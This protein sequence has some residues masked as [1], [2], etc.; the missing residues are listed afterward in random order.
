MNLFLVRHA[1]AVALELSGVN[2]DADRPLTQQGHA[3]S[4]AVATALLR[5]GV[6]LELVLTSPYLRCRQTTQGL[7]DAWAESRPKVEECEELAPE[8]KSGKL[9]RV[10][11]KQKVENLGVVGHMP[12]L[13]RYA[14]WLIGSKKARLDFA[15]ASVG[16]IDFPE[17]PDKGSGRLLWL[18]TPEWFMDS[19]ILVAGDG[20]PQ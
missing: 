6:R 4:R 8:G 5:L 1:E 18:V 16:L 10:L 7:I 9:A 15:K 2:S 17:L 19:T 3:Q 11:R 12:D 14:A 20:K 13:A